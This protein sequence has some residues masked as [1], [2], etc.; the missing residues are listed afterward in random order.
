MK[1]E[2]KTSASSWGG[3]AQQGAAALLLERNYK[4][5]KLRQ[6]IKRN[7]IDRK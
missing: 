2:I 4:D 1:N 6:W 7:G 5:V 3:W